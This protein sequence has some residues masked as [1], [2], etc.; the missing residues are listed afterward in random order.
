M[1]NQPS[2]GRLAPDL[3]A[4]KYNDFVS[5]FDN[6]DVSVLLCFVNVKVT[7]SLE[8]DQLNTGYIVQARGQTVH[9]FSVLFHANPFRRMLAG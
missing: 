8:C 1:T 4:V 3:G 9:F 6:C 7:Q 5:I 2:Q